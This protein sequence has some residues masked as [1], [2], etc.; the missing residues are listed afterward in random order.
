[1]KAGFYQF[2]IVFGDKARNLGKVTGA[3]A[4]AAFD[5]IVLP[6]L[7]NTGFLFSSRQEVMT[8]AEPVPDGETSQQLIGLAQQKHA[9]IVAGLAESENGRVYNTA[10]LVGPYGFVGKHRK[11][12][13]A[14]IERLL[15]DRGHEL[16]IFDLGGVRVGIVICIESWIPEIWRL[17]ALK[18]AQ[19]I[20]SPANFAGRRNT[21]IIKIRAQENRIH[22]INANRTG[23]ECHNGRSALF[24]G[25]S[26]IICP[27]GSILYRAGKQECLVV[28]DIRPIE[29]PGR[30]C[31]HIL[32]QKGAVSIR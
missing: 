25:E 1:M 9:H 30:G 29:T 7:F 19:V 26:Q 10:V 4:Q 16:D 21:D 23:M 3:L 18:G 32:A 12:H 13:L 6:E 11:T 2:D 15:F 5:L 20:C 8:Y 31:H 28:Q 17:L 22:T 24:R 14:P 27:D